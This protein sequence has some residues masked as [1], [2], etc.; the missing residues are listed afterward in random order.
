MNYRLLL[1]VLG[2]MLVAACAK[3]E[4]AAMQDTLLTSPS[5]PTPAP[6]PHVDSATGLWVDSSVIRQQ[7][8]IQVLKRFTPQEV[9]A[10]YDA[11][12]P[13][14]NSSTTQP[15]V[16]SFERAHRISSGELR[17]VL[18]E[19]DRLGWSKRGK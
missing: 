5:H 1:V 3:H 9:V 4:N 16:D 14:R 18:S 2:A 13:L 8:D 11:Y 17:S 6:G 7:P 15:E 12:R 10:L 19:G